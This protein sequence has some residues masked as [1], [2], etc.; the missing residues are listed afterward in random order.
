LKQITS[1]ECEIVMQPLGPVVLGVAAVLFS[2]PQMR[3]TFPPPTDAE[4][5]ELI[6]KLEPGNDKATRLAAVRRLN[7][8][9]WA[10]NA[11]LAVPAL[12]RCLREDP[13]KEVRREAVLD[14]AL[15][16]KRQGKPC[17]LAVFQALLDKGDEVR[18]Q[19]VACTPLF[20]KFDPGAVE[21]LLRCARSDDPHARAESLYLLARADRRDK[22]VLTA[23]ANAK[24]DKTFEVRNAAYTAHFRATE[25]LDEY[26]A[27]VIRLREDPDAVLS[28]LPADSEMRKQE[29][30]QRN[31]FMLGSAVQ[32]I[33]WSEKR[34]DELAAAL[35]KLLQDKAPLM[36]RGA[37][38]LIG[39]VAVKVESADPR[40]QSPDWVMHILPY[41]ESDSPYKALGTA[42][43]VERQMQ[44][45]AAAGVLEKLKVRELLSEL[46][47]NDPDEMVRDAARI[48]LA[49][50]AILDRKK[51]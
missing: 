21:I 10:K 33:E 39:T 6:A 20:D 30:M 22:R 7:G 12:E 41:V 23:I 26:L 49:R 40:K 17:P 24:K 38:N 46:R 42:P 43:K 18:W 19:A 28:P 14:L 29:R 8:H 50:L 3:N 15:I 44:R 47:D 4:M 13:E 48:A 25:R 5:K 2:P 32:L 16:A 9:S 1:K 27:Y 36:R 34:P 51:P 31:L 37:A 35:L 45:S 11:G